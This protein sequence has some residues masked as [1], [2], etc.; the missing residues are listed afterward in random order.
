MSSQPG[1]DYYLAI[2]T[3]GHKLFGYATSCRSH[4]FYYFWPWDSAS[5]FSDSGSSYRLYVPSAGL[6]D[7]IIIRLDRLQ[8]LRREPFALKVQPLYL[9]IDLALFVLIPLCDLLLVPCFSLIQEFRAWV[10]ERNRRKASMASALRGSSP[11][12]ILLMN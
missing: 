4:T 7:P 9:G 3:G 12:P 5:T 2:F 10:K 1:F 6:K 11:K 8:N